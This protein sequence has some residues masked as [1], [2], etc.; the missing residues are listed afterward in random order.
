MGSL[1]VLGTHRLQTMDVLRRHLQGVAAVNSKAPPRYFAESMYR[2]CLP[3]GHMGWP[4]V[5]Y[6][7]RGNLLQ[8]TG[9]MYYRNLKCLTR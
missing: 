4:T 3:P 7:L 6:F 8:E 9:P 5:N 1:I 2:L